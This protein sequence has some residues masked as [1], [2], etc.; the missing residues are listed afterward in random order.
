M[1]DQPKVLRLHSEATAEL[2]DSVSFYR[3][4]GGGRLA[5]RFKQHVLQGYNAIIANP[6]RYP[7]ERDVPGVQKFRLKHFPFSI[8]YINRPDHIWIVAIAHGS[9]KPGYWKDRIS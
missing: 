9:R 8:L 7:P 5:D 3:D 4:R 6:D 2:A 1:A